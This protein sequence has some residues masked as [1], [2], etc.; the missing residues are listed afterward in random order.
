MEI[1]ELLYYD[2]GKES[3]NAFGIITEIYPPP[4]CG[5][6]CKVLWFDDYLERECTGGAYEEFRQNIKNIKKHLNKQRE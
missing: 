2:S 6:I 4:N 1:G 3:H 5:F